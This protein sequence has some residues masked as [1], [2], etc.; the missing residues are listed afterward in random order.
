MKKV[1]IVEDDPM[2]ASINKQYVE[3]T[4]G[5]N[6][7]AT[8]HNGKDAWDFIRQKEIDLLI[9][10]VF[11]PQITGLEL[12]RLIREHHIHVDVIMVTA[13]NTSESI[14]EALSL[15]IL[16]YLVK[17]FQ[18][19]RFSMAISK[20]Q[21]KQKLMESHVEFT[22]KDVDNLLLQQ[23]SR[24]KEPEKE[25]RKGLQDATLRTLRE[26]LKKRTVMTTEDLSEATGLSKVTVRRY[27][28]Y[29]IDNNE[30]SS[31]VDYHT[32]GRPRMNYRYLIH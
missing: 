15:G 21:L 25:L 2:V 29:L 13:S 24:G 12:L 32:G 10:D 11:M 17:P 1:L 19:D 9:L 30:V 8:I 28:N 27:M 31:E 22:Q 7:I 5:M 6:V 18:Y 14:K 3:M 16:D 4:K 26:C 23:I 20:F